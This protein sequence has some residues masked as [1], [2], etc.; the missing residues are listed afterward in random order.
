MG[1]IVQLNRD[2]ARH[3]M[4]R[5]GTANISIPVAT[6]STLR[7]GIYGKHDRPR[8]EFNLRLRYV[9]AGVVID[10]GTANTNVMGYGF[11][12]AETGHGDVRLLVPTEA[13]SLGQ[14]VTAA[15]LTPPTA[16]DIALLEW[17]T[18]LD[19]SFRLSF[20]DTHSVISQ[21]ATALFNTADAAGQVVGNGAC[22]LAAGVSPNW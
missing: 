6:V 21:Q 7:F 12:A 20:L 1:L 8:A 10:K 3:F 18:P 4:G 15:G 19:P 9:S 2:S 22:W 14:A 11:T 13:R 16:G 17:P 5:D